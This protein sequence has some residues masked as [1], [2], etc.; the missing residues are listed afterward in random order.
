VGTGDYENVEDNM[1]ALLNNFLREESGQDLIEYTLLM[2][3]VAL[4]SASIFLQA[5]N[6]VGTIWQ[7]GSTQISNAAVAAS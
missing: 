6:S 4:A 3:F 1:K 5:G 2:A 7:S